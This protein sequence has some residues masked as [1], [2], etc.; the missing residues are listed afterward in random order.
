MELDKYLLIQLETALDLH[1][2]KNLASHFGEMVCGYIIYNNA[3]WARM[4]IESPIA[5]EGFQRYNISYLTLEDVCTDEKLRVID[6]MDVTE[7]EVE[8]WFNVV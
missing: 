4:L 2:V 1:V 6:S 5:E 3:F 7:R 8:I